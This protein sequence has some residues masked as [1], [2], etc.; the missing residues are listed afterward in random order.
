[1]RRWHGGV[2]GCSWDGKKKVNSVTNEDL[3]TVRSD[4]GSL[5]V[6]GGARRRGRY[7]GVGGYDGCKYE[8]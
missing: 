8:E 4:K 6:I 3:W 2:I 5:G 7:L 1:M